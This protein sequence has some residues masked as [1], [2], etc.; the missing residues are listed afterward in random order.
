M[1]DLV[2]EYLAL[3]EQVPEYVGFYRPKHHFLQHLARDAW[4]YGPPRGYWCFGFEGF[5]RVVKHG[6]KL[7][8]FKS[9]SRSVMQYWSVRSGMVCVRRA[10]AESCNSVY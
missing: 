1:D 4:R 8:N 3:F 9:E 7:S 2:L 5:N 10:R 6:A